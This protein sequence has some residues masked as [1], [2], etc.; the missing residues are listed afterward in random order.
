MIKMTMPE[1]ICICFI[2][3]CFGVHMGMFITILVTNNSKKD[4]QTNDEAAWRDAM[5]KM[6][7]WR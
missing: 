7:Y 4:K 5:K 1:I 6:I 2:C 3:T